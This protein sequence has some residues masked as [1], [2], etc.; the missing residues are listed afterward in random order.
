[1]VK[2]YFLAKFQDA[3]PM[4]STDYNYESEHIYNW[5]SSILIINIDV[6][7]CQAQQIDNEPLYLFSCLC[8]GVTL[9][10]LTLREAIDGAIKEP[11]LVCI[12]LFPSIIHVY[13][14]ITV[15]CSYTDVFYVQD[16]VV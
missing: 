11:V 16:F 3:C 9:N 10:L 6:V 4:L 5:G 13:S 2:K 7:I 1:M 8:L 14:D 15:G 12:I